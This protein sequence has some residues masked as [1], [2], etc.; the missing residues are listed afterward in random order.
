MKTYPNLED[1][2][3]PGKNLLVSD[4][5]EE[6]IYQDMANHESELVRREAEAI[7]ESHKIIM[8]G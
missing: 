1:F 5:I 7:R 8:E 4:T 3:I 2:V 6:K